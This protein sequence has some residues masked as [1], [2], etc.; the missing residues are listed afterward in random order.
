LVFFVESQQG[1]NLVFKGVGVGKTITWQ[2]YFHSIDQSLKDPNVSSR[3][4]TWK[5]HQQTFGND[6]CQP[7]H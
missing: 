3:K 4:N 2:G 5:N 7:D 1:D 6:W